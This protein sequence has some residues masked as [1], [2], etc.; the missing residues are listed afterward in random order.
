MGQHMFC[1]PFKVLWFE[2]FLIP[3]AVC[4]VRMKDGNIFMAFFLTTSDATS[5]LKLG[6]WRF[7]DKLKVLLWKKLFLVYLLSLSKLSWEN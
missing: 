3:T 2:L 7:M 4:I 5:F 6:D 1:F